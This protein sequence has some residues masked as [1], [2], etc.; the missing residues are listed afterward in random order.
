MC[1]V[2]VNEEA[3]NE[4]WK[5]VKAMRLNFIQNAFCGRIY[6]IWK[7]APN[8]ITCHNCPCAYRIYLGGIAGIM[9]MDHGPRSTSKRHKVFWEKAFLE[10]I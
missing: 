6:Y 3:L 1:G 8:A 10:V 2:L 9:I 4:L 7:T 5:A